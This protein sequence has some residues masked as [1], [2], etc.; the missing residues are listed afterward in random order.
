[1]F[2]RLFGKSRRDEAPASDPGTQAATA[3][4]RPGPEPWA[5]GPPRDPGPWD[6][7]PH[8][9]GWRTWVGYAMG[10]GLE[11]EAHAFARLDLKEARRLVDP[12]RQDQLLDLISLN[13]H[14]ALKQGDLASA[15]RLSQ[16]ALEIAI[17]HEGATGADRAQ[18][19]VR[20]ADVERM[21]GRRAAALERYRE[22]LD[23]RR[24]VLGPDHD[25]TRMLDDYIARYDV[26][27]PSGLPPQEER[28]DREIQRRLQDVDAIV[29]TRRLGVAEPEL[30]EALNVA[31][32]YKGRSHPRTADILLRL[33]G[34]LGQM[35][36]HQDAHKY[37]MH[38]TDVVGEAS[39][40]DGP[41]A[42]AALAALKENEQAIR[43]GW[44]VGPAEG[45]TIEVVL[46]DEHL[47]V[48][49]MDRLAR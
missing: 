39:G 17:G 2:R 11:E 27:A 42:A 18:A 5:P 10:N 22:A 6:S 38:H 4:A 35:S 20:L 23:L 37:L 32:Q 44:D 41:E 30:R 29:R 21:E 8:R 3:S 46:T 1:M 33:G 9:F 15:R 45:R 19:L 34:L 48:W 36:H 7:P 40:H 13:A 49:L 47:H 26:D 24:A 25:H 14:L 28:A 31:V 12:F 43:A 16:E